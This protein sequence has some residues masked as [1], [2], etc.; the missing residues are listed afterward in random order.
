MLRDWRAPS[1]RRT[2]R[3]GQPGARVEDYFW[4]RSS[5]YLSGLWYAISP[6]GTHDQYESPSG[7]FSYLP[8]FLNSVHS[9]RHSSIR[10]LSPSL[11]TWPSFASVVKGMAISAVQP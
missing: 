2:D 7:T 6:V 5:P 9:I 11:G 3:C 8:L 1:N 10:Q 4:K